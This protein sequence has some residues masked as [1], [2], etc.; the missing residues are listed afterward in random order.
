[1][2]PFSKQRA[3]GGVF[4]FRHQLPVD[5]FDRL[6]EVGTPG[7]RRT[8]TFSLRTRDPEVARSRA[9]RAAAD[10]GDMI[11]AVRSGA[12]PPWAFDPAAYL[13]E[14]GSVPPMR[15]EPLTSKP[16]ADAKLAAGMTMRRVYDEVYLPRSC[17]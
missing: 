12:T 1:M 8:V 16:K 9:L 13:H 11:A 6:V 10:V 14:R 4:G 15:P 5:V 7:V 17:R 2:V 3:K